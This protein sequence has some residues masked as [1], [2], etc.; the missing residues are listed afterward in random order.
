[1]GQLVA[2][3]RDLYRGVVPVAD[4]EGD[5]GR[6]DE[7]VAVAA[8]ESGDPHQVKLVEACR[9]GFEITGD[10]GFLEASRT[11]TG[12]DRSAERR[13]PVARSSGGATKSRI[14]GPCYSRRPT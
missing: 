10:A 1:M 13:R 8:A 9:R 3:H 14:G 7:D 11:V 5:P 12:L 2:E 6:W 4:D